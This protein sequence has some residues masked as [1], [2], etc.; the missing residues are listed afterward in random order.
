MPD[1]ACGVCGADDE[2][3]LVIKGICGF[4]MKIDVC[5]KFSQSNCE[6]TDL[7]RGIGCVGNW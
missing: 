2:K 5:F 1:V 6:G 3:S 7:S 4:G